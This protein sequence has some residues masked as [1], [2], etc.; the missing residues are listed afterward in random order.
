M[1]PAAPAAEQPAAVAEQPAEKSEPAAEA[2]AEKSGE[3]LC[4]I[5]NKPGHVARNCP[6]RRTE[7]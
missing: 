6:E 1:E 3:R 5:C 2:S 7:Q 4:R